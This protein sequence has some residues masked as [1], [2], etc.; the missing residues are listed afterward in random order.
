[1]FVG[2]ERSQ[3]AVGKSPDQVDA[4]LERIRALA[5]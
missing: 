4:T 1:M 3:G 2:L 5:T